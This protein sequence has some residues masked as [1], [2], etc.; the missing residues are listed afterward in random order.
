MLPQLTTVPF[1][2]SVTVVSAANES[3]STHLTRRSPSVLSC[4]AMAEEDWD[5]LIDQYDRG[6]RG[7]SVIK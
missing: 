5:K 3:H 2:P 7:N 4:T 1:A 6:H